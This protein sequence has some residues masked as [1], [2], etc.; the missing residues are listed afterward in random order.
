M[1]LNFPANPSANQT[2]TNAGITWTWNGR[3]WTKPGASGSTVSKDITWANV[4]TANFTANVGSGY[5]VNTTSSA[6]TV[7]LPQNPSRGDQVQ[8]LDYAGTWSSN[9]VTVA[10]NG[11]NINGIALN[12]FLATNRGASTL[13]YVDSTQGWVGSDAFAVTELGGI[14]VDYLVVAGGGG[15]GAGEPNP[16]GDGGGGGGAGGYISGSATFTMGIKNITVGAGGNGSTSHVSAGS[17]GGNSVIS[18]TG[19]TSVTAYGGGGGGSGTVSIPLDGGSGGGAGNEYSASTPAGKGVYPGSSYISAARQGYDGGDTLNN[20]ISQ[21]GG[22][23]GGGSAGAGSTRSSGGGAGGGPGTS[24][25]ITGSAVTYA[26]GGAGG[27]VG[28]NA[29]GSSA[30]SSTGNGGNGGGSPSSGNAQYIGGSGGSGV[31]IIAY[32]DI[33]P[34]LASIGAGLTYDQPTR[35]GYR[36]YRFTQGTGTISW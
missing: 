23:G 25:S 8:L 4:R 36:V 7:T 34:A 2:Y 26:A 6:I 17:R 33:Y 11:S 27:S 9:I 32:P 16:G 10:R 31:V 15:A 19:F 24:N 28:S 1:P 13:T 29:N 18:G 35:S 30:S 22:S 20:S 5:P 12:M 14:P 21:R 3:T